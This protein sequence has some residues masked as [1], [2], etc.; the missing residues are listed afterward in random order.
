[1][2]LLSVRCKKS[3]P[4]HE[5]IFQQPDFLRMTLRFIGRLK[6]KGKQSGSKLYAGFDP[7]PYVAA[8]VKIV[9]VAWG[10]FHSDKV[11]CHD[12]MR[13]CPDPLIRKRAP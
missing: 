1:M 12:L 11:I 6:I 8:G 5:S 3:L 2:I 13:E 9:E 10:I 4:G 7:L